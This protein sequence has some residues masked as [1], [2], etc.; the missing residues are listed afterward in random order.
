[1]GEDTVCC[2]YSEPM[3]V[4]PVDV[5]T[6]F[7][8]SHL[9]GRAEGGDNVTLLT[10][11]VDPFDIEVELFQFNLKNEVLWRTS[12]HI[13]KIEDNNCR[14][15]IKTP[16]YRNLKRAKVFF[17]LYQPS[18]RKYGNKWPF[19]YCPPPLY[20][21][22]R[23]IF[24]TEPLLTFRQYE[25]PPKK[26]SKGFKKDLL[27]RATDKFLVDENGNTVIHTCVMRGNLDL[28]V[29]F[30]NELEESIV[31]MKN[32]QKMSALLMAAHLEETE[33]CA[34][35]LT[36]ADISA[37]DIFGNNVLHLACKKK[38]LSLLHLFLKRAEKSLLNAT[39]NDGFTPLH[40]AVLSG[41]LDIFCAFNNQNVD[42]NAKDTRR[43]Y[44]AL[45]YA[46]THSSLIHVV[47]L[48]VKQTGI[49]LDAKS[50]T[51]STP[52][53]V[54]V[55]NKN[56]MTTVCLVGKSLARYFFYFCV[57]TFLA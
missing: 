35:L 12:A 50:L 33:M 48:L 24:S 20:D 3:N 11:S 55:A 38:N 52:L 25:P 2:V 8:S 29:I 54:A 51:G 4:T 5:L 7:E 46:C 21:E 53:H 34:H 26:R 32:G 49:D 13:D 31:N 15:L 40:L 45:H 28:L 17:R 37:T 30:V 56:Y 39:N 9:Y 18:T 43:G 47:N 19:F 23:A 14:L 1:M 6:I 22:Y 27:A 57:K 42:L 16:K 41:S 36:K 44:T 10:S